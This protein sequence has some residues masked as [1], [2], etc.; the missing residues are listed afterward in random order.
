MHTSTVNRAVWANDACIALRKNPDKKIFQ[1]GKLYRPRVLYWEKNCVPP[2]P[3]IQNCNP[4]KYIA[5]T[6]T[7]FWKIL[8]FSSFSKM[9]YTAHCRYNSVL[10]YAVVCYATVE[11]LLIVLIVFP[12]FVFVH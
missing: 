1:M 7:E 11:L 9:E 3:K 12:V 8:F 10:V 5:G 2:M 4:R 6:P